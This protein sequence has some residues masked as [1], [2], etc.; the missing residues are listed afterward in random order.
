MISAR[1]RAQPTNL[2]VI[3]AP[4]TAST[5]DDVQAFYFQLQECPDKCPPQDIKFVANDLNAKVGT[6]RSNWEQ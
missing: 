4:T 2:T 5:D 1:F 6:Y 3:H